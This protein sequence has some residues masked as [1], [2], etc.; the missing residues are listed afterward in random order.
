[1][2]PGRDF[3][4]TLLPLLGA[5]AL[6]GLWTS[7]AA[8]QAQGAPRERLIP[9]EVTINGSQ[10][11]SWALLEHNG[12]LY[13]PAEAFDEWRVTRRPDAVP[14]TQR[15]QLWY[16]LASVPGFQAQLNMA[17]QSVDLVF[18]PAAFAATRVTAAEEARP[19]LSTV[20][21]ALFLNFDTNLSYNAPRSAKATKEVGALAEVGW[22]TG[23]GVLT[24]SYVGR[25]LNDP[26]PAQP[27]NVR[28]LE[29]T[30]TR[31]FPDRNVTLRLGD[32]ATRTGLWGRGIY[33][34]GVHLTR[35]FSL[36]PG[37]VTQPIPLIS[38]TS[39]APSTVELYVNDALRQTSQVPTGPFVVDNFPQL[40]GAGQARL[41]VRD[42]LGRETVI[43]QPFFSHASLLD[44]GL[45]DW[46]MEVGAVR[47]NLGTD[48][49]NYGERFTSGMWRYGFSRSLTLETRAELARETQS[50]GLGLTYALPW[51]MLGVAALAASRDTARGSGTQWVAGVEHDSL[52][53]GFSIRAEGAS[54]GFR[55]VGLDDRTL[56]NR[57]EFSASYS[58]NS[59]I[60]SLGFAVARI[61]SFD[62]GPLSTY[63]LNYSRRIGARSSLTATL[64]HVQGPGGTS[65][66][67]AMGV[68]LTV[69]MDNHL[70]LASSATYKSEQ[71]QLEAYAS[72]SKGLSA[73]T[74]VGWRVLGGTRASSPHAEG[75]L[76][77]QGDKMLLTGDL[78]ASREQAA[79]RLGAQ[80]GLV[81]MGGRL[82][83]SRRVDN[84]FALV[85]V[86]GHPNVGVGFQGSSLT[87]TD[88]AGFALLPRLVPY[89]TNSIRLDPTELPISAELDTIEQTA[90]PAMRSG[91]RVVFPV[92]SG[93]GAL[94]RIVLDDG[95]PAPAG[96]EVRIAGDTKEF[97]VARRGESFVTGLKEKNMLRL[98][99]NGASCNFEVLL[100]AG[101][102]D[103]IARVG[104]LACRGVKR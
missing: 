26:D 29:T 53:H 17:N 47:R 64:T 65:T 97:F 8:Q 61:Q 76:Y 13:A 54:I 56:P 45:V 67:T 14:I 66:G 85:E 32:S 103:E 33:F 2:R 86:P 48:S 7:A 46:S 68:T 81:L 40:T 59:D 84:S 4:L 30:F 73:E 20:E 16:P 19:A 36:T 63:S 87:R 80:G 6:G 22:A 91:V 1:M 35:N 96:A 10:G 82:F 92:R 90:V 38:G 15:G 83:A 51:Q 44:Q 52:R 50:G 43:V 42:V 93:R 55:Q 57:L 69:P 60:G 71:R 101:S 28:R 37:F 12:V 75:G 27:R 24:S 99:W 21:P 49:A 41:V 25:N 72:A 3:R 102:P 9:L 23:W 11:G 100:P 18:S 98:D 58:Y 77:Y 70:N 78:S 62:R 39:S 88:S 31:D 89:Q 34:G 94:L 79:V 95:E 74:G 104:P 5:L